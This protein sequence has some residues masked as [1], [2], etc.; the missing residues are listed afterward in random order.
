MRMGAEDI[1][2]VDETPHADAIEQHQTV[3]LGEETGLDVGYLTDI[4]DRDADH[5]DLMDQATIVPV[6]EPDSVP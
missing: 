3:D 1:V 2:P 6:A 5:G 4:S